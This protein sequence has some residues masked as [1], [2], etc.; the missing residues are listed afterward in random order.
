[1]QVKAA[2][3]E[4]RCLISKMKNTEVQQPDPELLLLILS[5]VAEE[6]TLGILRSPLSYTWSANEHE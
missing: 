1:M 2:P 5:C 6:I 4:K 3:E